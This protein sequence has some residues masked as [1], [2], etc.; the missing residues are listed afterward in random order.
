MHESVDHPKH[1]QG[2]IECIDA[3]ALVLSEGQFAQPPFYPPITPAIFFNVVKYRW[4]EH[5]KNGS[6]DLAKAEWYRNWFINH[7]REQYRPEKIT[8]LM[9]EFDALVDH[10]LAMR[11]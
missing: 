7:L 10:A 9:H 5:L 2:K 11:D 3:I 8:V 6:E 4:R 1:Y